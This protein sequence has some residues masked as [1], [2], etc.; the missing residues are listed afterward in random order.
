MRT[1]LPAF[2]AIGF[3]LSACSYSVIKK[4]ASA[5]VFGWDQSLV[6][7]VIECK[8]AYLEDYRSGRYEEAFQTASRLIAVTQKRI[9]RGEVDE[10]YLLSDL[11]DYLLSAAATGR[12]S[13]I[14][15]GIRRFEEI[16]DRLKSS[17]GISN[18]AP[19]SWSKL[20]H[21]ALY[22]P[23]DSN[24]AGARH[25]LEKL[26]PIFEANFHYG[27][28]LNRLSEMKEACVALK[29]NLPGS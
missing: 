24:K 22:I 7:E 26:I 20:G 8:Q 25:L 13:E 29:C 5:V 27:P 2:L 1:S 9:N 16:T 21:T 23:K 10:T 18:V 3:T 28:E 19:I 12:L 14:E 15:S 6:H 11:E 4:T 17:P